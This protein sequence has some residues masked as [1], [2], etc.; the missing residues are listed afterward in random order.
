[1]ITLLQ[2]DCLEVLKTLPDNSIQMCVT[3]PPYY[4]LRD[5]DVDGQIGLEKTPE[6]YVAKLVDVFREVRRVLRD[7]GTLWLNLGDSYVGGGRGGNTG[8]GKDKSIIRSKRIERGN[9]R[10]GD[11]NVPATGSLKPKDLIGIPWM[12]AF[13][14]RADGWWL[15]SEIIWYKLNP[16]PGS[17]RDRPA[18]SHEQIFLFSKSATYYYDGDAIREPYAE[19]SLPRA[20][21]GLSKDNKWSK[22]PGSTAHSISQARPNA[23]LSGSGQAFGGDGHK[24]YIDANGRLL[25][26]P[27]G[28]NC[29]DVWV[30]ATNAYKGAHFATFP[31]EI[32][33][34]CI[35]TGSKPGDVILDPFSGAGTTGL[36]AKQLKRDYI[37]ID[38]NPEYNEMAR[39]RIEAEQ[40]PL[41]I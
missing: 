16:M 13:A 40:E 22:A 41:L 5:Y 21:R 14:L 34:R 9:G 20:M 38:L 23:K 32:P 18:S 1:L 29:R 35:K 7:D 3:S 27:M 2:G 4:G 28:R 19:A 31:P 25:I 30:I 26:N 11:G 8:K 37:G 17:A 10:W 36:V 6:E 39:K 24:G 33:E 12:V 15:R